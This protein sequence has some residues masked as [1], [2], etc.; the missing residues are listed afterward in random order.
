MTKIIQ[1]MAFSMV[2]RNV[3]GADPRCGNETELS[4][5]GVVY[6]DDDGEPKDVAVM[7]VAFKVCPNAE[8]I[9]EFG[10]VYPIPR[11]FKLNG[12]HTPS[13]QRL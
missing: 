9:A 2:F 5:S 11:T 7:H 4:F 13:D 10:K 3:D 12:L 1:H 8:I 6:D